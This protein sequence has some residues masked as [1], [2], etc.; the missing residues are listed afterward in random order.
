M[1]DDFLKKFIFALYFLGLDG[2]E[3]VLS[4]Q[5]DPFQACQI[6]PCIW[7]SFFSANIYTKL[8]ENN[9]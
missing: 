3:A 2:L 5:R 8:I 1:E 4:N 6:V 7:Y 9:V